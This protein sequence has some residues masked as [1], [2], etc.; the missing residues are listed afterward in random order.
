MF[1]K[2]DFTSKLTGDLGEEKGHKF[3]A[4]GAIIYAKG[5]NNARV[6]VGPNVALAAAKDIK[7]NST[8]KIE[9]LFIYSDS[10]AVSRTESATGEQNAVSAA[11]IYSDISQDSSV[12]FDD[13]A[14]TNSENQT[15]VTGAK[16]GINSSAEIEYNRIN[17]MIQ[18]VKD[19][20]ATL[21]TTTMSDYQR[22][23]LTDLENSWQDV[24]NKF[25]AVGAEGLTVSENIKAFSSALVSLGG[26]VGA[27]ADMAAGEVAVVANAAQVVSA[28]SEFLSYN[29]FLN[30]S[31]SSTV[32]GGSAE[33]SENIGVSGM[34]GI[35]NFSSN[36]DV[37]IGRNVTLKTPTPGTDDVAIDINSSTRSEMITSA[38]HIIPSSGATSFGGTYLT[39]DYDLISNVMV[40]E[41]ADI[42]SGTK[43][44][45]LNSENES[46]IA[47]L[48]LSTAMAASG[49]DGMYSQ[50]KADSKAELKI[51]DEVSIDAR[52]LELL[53]SNNSKVMNVAGSV[54][55]TSAK[56]AGV[57]IAVNDLT[58]TSVAAI[59]D[60]DKEYQD[61]LKVKDSNIT[62]ADSQR[63]RTDAKISLARELSS[64]A[65]SKGRVMAL[66]VAG[67][68][69]TN[70]D[71]SEPGFFSNLG[72]KFGSI[73]NKVTDKIDS[74]GT[75][76]GTGITSQLQDKS[77]TTDP[78]AGHTNP[79]F[80]LSVAGSLGLNNVDNTTTAE[81][82]EATIELNAAND[83]NL[84]LSAI[85]DSDVLAGAGA[86]GVM[87]Q[88]A[89][90]EA[91][92]KAKSVS[93]AGAAGINKLVSNT[94]ALIS[95]SVINKAKNME[96]YA[97][98]GG[99]T[100][101]A[102]LGMQLSK[103]TGNAKEAYTAGSSISINLIEN[104]IKALVKNS[105][106]DGKTVKTN[107]DV[108]AY[109]GGNQYTGG[110]Q[111]S[112]GTVNGAIGA[113]VNVANITNN[114]SSQIAGGTYSN[115]NAISVSALQALTQVNA[116][117]TAG[118]IWGTD[119]STA[120][121]GALVYNAL[122]NQ[123]NS[124]I[125]SD[126]NINADADVSLVACDS[127][128]LSQDF[129]QLL[130]QSDHDFSSFI[131]DNGSDYANVS[132]ENDVDDSTTALD[133]ST[134]KGGLIVTSAA[135]LNSG[136]G[137]F[138]AGLVINNI[139]NDYRA[140]IDSSTV[141]ADSIKTKAINNNLFV[142]VAGG[143]AVASKNVA[144]SGSA[145]WNHIDATI[146]S[147]HQNSDLTANNFLVQALNASK[148]TSVA[149]TIA[150]GK[151][152]IGLAFSFNNLN[153]NINAYSHATNI[154]GKNAGAST[155]Q[156][157]AENA[158]DLLNIGACAEISSELSFGGSLIIN[159]IIDTTKATVNNSYL[160]Q[161]DDQQTRSNVEIKNIKSVDINANNNSK[162]K[163][164]VADIV[165]SKEAGLG[166]ARAHNLIKND[167]ESDPDSDQT[168]I[169]QASAGNLTIDAESVDIIAKNS[170]DINAWATGFAIAGESAVNGAIAI[171]VIDRQ[172]DA[173]AENLQIN[174]A[175]SSLNINS[176]SDGTIKSRALVAAAS[177]D[178][179]VG[180]GVATNRITDKV[181]AYVSDGEL[182]LKNLEVN[183]AASHEIHA[184]GVSGAAGSATLS[185]SVG[186]NV[187]D[188][189]N[190]AYI[191][192]GAKV[193]AQ[194]NVG[195]VALT[196]DLLGNYA[197]VAAIGAEAGIGA[198]VSVN[199]ILGETN[200]Y[201][202]EATINAKGAD[203]GI[204]VKT[205]ISDDDMSEIYDE[206]LQAAKKHNLQTK[207]QETTQKGIVIDS[208]S[209]ASF[210]SFTANA[211]LSGEVALA[212]T[213]NVN[214][215]DG[216][217]SAMLSQ[218]EINNES[219]YN[220]D[221]VVNSADYNNLSSFV[222]SAEIAGAAGVGVSVDTNRINRESV[223][224]IDRV[225]GSKA[226]NIHLNATSKQ[227]MS[228][229]SAGLALGGELGIAGS[230]STFYLTGKTRA[231][232]NN[233]VLACSDMNINA[234]R[235]AKT[236]SNNSTISA[237][238]GGIGGSVATLIDKQKV[239]AIVKSAH[240][241]AIGAVDIKTKNNSV[242]HT[243]ALG[244]G[245]G[246][247]GG[248]GNVAVNYI[249]TDVKAELTGSSIG[250]SNEAADSISIQANNSS[251]LKAEIGTAGAGGL[252]AGLSV[253]VN[254][255]DGKVRT[256][257]DH[258][259]LFANN[260]I[261]VKTHNH[262]TAEVKTFTVAAGV[263]AASVNVAVLSSGKKLE[264]S[265][266]D[267]NK[268]ASDGIDA[269]EKSNAGA[270]DNTH[271]ALTESE[272]KDLN[273]TTTRPVSDIDNLSETSLAIANNSSVHSSNGGVFI[274]ATEKTDSDFIGGAES[275]GGAAAGA[276]VAIMNL[277]RN[278]GVTISDSSV[279]SMGDLNIASTV[280]GASSLKTYQGT[281]AAFAGGT[282]AYSRV[283]TTGSSFIDI[284]NAA[285]TSSGHI[286]L[287]GQ[288][289]SSVDA[290]G[291]GL[292]GS[293]L[294]AA[295]YLKTKIVND[296]S[297]NVK[298]DNN[299]N[300]ISDKNIDVEAS[301]K[302]ALTS[303]AKNGSIGLGF[304]GTGVSSEIIDSGMAQV[305]QSGQGSSYTGKKISFSA[306]NK[307]EIT[308][309]ATGDSK[310][311]A[312]S[313]ALSFASS[314][315]TS[316]TIVEFGSGNYF[317]SKNVA[318]LGK[319]EG[320]NTVFTNG[321]SGGFV[322]SFGYNSS[323]AVNDST[324]NISVGDNEYQTDTDLQLE[325]NNNVNQTA[326]T[327]GLSVGGLIASG[328]NRSETVSKANISVELA[329]NSTDDEHLNSVS[330][331]ADSSNSNFSYAN[332]DGG[333]LISS[334][335]LSAKA[336]NS[337]NNTVVA[338][339]S[340]KWNIA[341]D[342][343]LNA[344]QTVA[345]T[346]KSSSTKA[347]VVGYSGTMAN[348]NITM[349][350]T[351]ELAADS[352]LLTGGDTR[353]KAL[354]V[355]G[356]GKKN[357]VTAA[358]GGYGG[359][360]VNGSN[361]TLEINSV[362]DAK[363]GENSI[364][365]STRGKINI[366]A[367]TQSE[368]YN[369]AK[370]S[371][372]GVVGVPVAISNNDLTIENSA[373][374]ADQAALRTFAADKDISIA[375]FDKTTAIL[376]SVSDMQGGLGGEARA[377][378]N[379]TIDRS[380]SLDIK[381]A[382]T[383]SNDVN[384]YTD[385]N[386]AG[387][388]SDYSLTATADAY[389]KHSAVALAKAE[390]NSTNNL[391]NQINIAANSDI[392]S[393]RHIN[394]GA[395]SGRYY[396]SELANEYTWYSSDTSGGH[397][398][399]ASGDNS[400]S[401]VKNNHVAIDG[402][403]IA[404]SQNKLDINI[405]G[406]V[407]F[408]KQIENSVD[409]PQI[410]INNEQYAKLIKYGDFD[411]GNALFDRF[412]EVSKLAVEYVGS[413]AGIGYEAEKL[414]LLDEMERFGLYDPA[415]GQV[416]GGMIV[417]YIE[418]P[419]MVSSGG[420]LIINTDKVQGT[421]TIKAQGSPKINI[422]N[423]SNLYTKLGG[424]QIKDYG[425]EVILNKV[426]LGEEAQAKLPTLKTVETSDAREAAII[427]KQEWQGTVE[428]Q[429]DDGSKR[430]FKPLTSIEINGNVSNPLGTIFVQTKQ[431]DIVIQ[432]KTAKESVSVSGMEVTL[433][434]DQGS[435]AQGFTKGIVNVNSNP[436]DVYEHYWDNAKETNKGGEKTKT[437]KIISKND[438]D[439]AL[440]HGI[441]IAGGSVYI[442]A[443]DININGL[444]QSGY[445]TYN[446]TLDDAAET[447]IKNFDNNYDGRTI[448]SAMLKDYALNE[449]GAK[450]VFQKTVDSTTVTV[451]KH[452]Y[453]IQ[454]YYNP[455]TQQI[456]LEEV[457]PQG[458]KIFL[459]GRV[460]S[461]GNGRIV[462][463][464]GAAEVDIT[465]NTFRPI[466]TANIGSGNAEGLVRIT[467]SAKGL[468]T[469]FRRDSTTNYDIGS[470]DKTLSA[471]SSI[472]KPKEGL[473]YNWTTGL[474]RTDEKYKKYVEKFLFWGGY[475]Y[476]KDNVETF[477]SDVTPISNNDP[478]I[479]G[480]YI[481]NFH[482][483]PGAEF[484]LVYENDPHYTSIPN[485]NNPWI[486]RHTEYD[487]KLHFHGKNIYEAGSVQGKIV[488]YQ[489]SLNASNDVS[490]RFIG[491]TT[492]GHI[493]ITSIDDITLKGDV[494]GIEGTNVAIESRVGAIDQISG[495]ISADKVSLNAEKGIGNNYG[496][497]H[498]V[499]SDTATINAI[500]TSGNITINSIASINKQGNLGLIAKAL[501][502]KVK[503]TSDGSI[504]GQLPLSGDKASVI[505]RR[506]DLKS[507]EE[508]VDITNLSSNIDALKKLSSAEA[509]DVTW[510][511]DEGIAV[512]KR[513][514]GIGIEMSS[515]DG[516]LKATANK[517][518][519]IAASTD[520][521]IY[522]D[523]INAG[524][525]NI[526]LLGRDGVYN[527]SSLPTTVNLK[528]KDLII[529]G[530][531]KG[532]K[533]SIGEINRPI[534]IDLSGKLT[535]RAE[536]LINISQM[537]TD[538]MIL[539]ALYGASDV[540][541]KALNNI[542]S[543]YSGIPSEDLG[544]INTAGKLTLI[545]AQGDIGES[546]KGL[547]ILADNTESVDA[548]GNDI[549]LSLKTESADDSTL[550]FTSLDT[551]TTGKIE[552]IGKDV[553]V[554]FSA[555][556]NA[557]TIS[558]AT[559][560]ATQSGNST[561]KTASLNATTS[562]GQIFANNNNE[563][564]SAQLLNSESGNIS[565]HTT[566]ILSIKSAI[567]QAESGNL[568]L[569][570]ASTIT[571]SGNISAGGDITINADKGFSSTATI[572]S[573]NDMHLT[574]N[575]GFVDFDKIDAGG[576]IDI[577][578]NGYIK[579]DNLVA[580]NDIIIDD[581]GGDISLNKADAGRDIIMTALDSNINIASTFEADRDLKVE[582]KDLIAD[583]LVAGRDLSLTE[584]SG[585]IDFVSAKAG[586]DVSLTTAKS[587]I[588]ID[589]V[590]AGRDLE[591]L[592]EYG[593]IRI[594]DKV[595]SRSGSVNLI[596]DG[597][598]NVHEILAR[599]DIK[600]LSNDGEIMI[601][602]LNGKR[603]TLVVNHDKKTVNVDEVNVGHE[604]TV[605]ASTVNVDKVKHTSD[606]DFLKMCFSGVNNSNMDDINIRQ[607]DSQ[608]GVRVKGLWTI[609]G[610]LHTNSEYFRLEDVYFI[611]RGYLSNSQMTMT[612]FGQNPMLDGSDVII[613]FM[614]T[615]SGV[616]T[617][618]SFQNEFGSST[619]YTLIYA[620]DRK[621]F[622]S[623]EFTMM[624][625]AA[626]IAKNDILGAGR[627]SQAGDSQMFAASIASNI[628][629]DDHIFTELLQQYGLNYSA[630]QHSSVLLAYDM[631]SGTLYSTAQSD[632]EDIKDQE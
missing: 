221:L 371:G 50:L 199:H 604:M 234:Y 336:I 201:I 503:I 149:G 223:A 6:K 421:G 453:E 90:T 61:Y 176:A 184:I 401:F 7:I 170:A 474:N 384:F 168:S 334:D 259:N 18:D 389:N 118:I 394:L 500:T 274:T 191:A 375:A 432:G 253:G 581:L 528:G 630:S 598:I 473:Y 216:K 613:Y 418:L 69:I 214:T 42:V 512:I 618:I 440:Q 235:W 180:A 32:K 10:K 380:N 152:A 592:S 583:T 508:I 17:R 155:L 458:G 485:S 488:T 412:E 626:A 275:A 11:I 489:H 65:E 113:A 134:K 609:T 492:G 455:Q 161:D 56:G 44:S 391:N 143:V 529:E 475:T 460:S 302:N 420:N 533:S 321:A 551:D 285:L 353:I 374:I 119:S 101:A 68:I 396:L 159:E 95:D 213:V 319:V 454:A 356:V 507:T 217:T 316:K 462:A 392:S 277:N 607:I 183:S 343:L 239:H 261:A 433:T 63:N 3:E 169:T 288:D 238:L 476:G 16:I 405:S 279:S 15:I 399:T 346:L 151:N 463:F 404:G 558:L 435:V 317:N 307:P 407:D 464:D 597:D 173:H 89:T 381:G 163:S 153:N 572:N 14:H 282:A 313:G 281:I 576:D 465:N 125:T 237:G 501:D 137:A 252:G 569:Q 106:V 117:L 246:V 258:S 303:T 110:A 450:Y 67:G 324:V 624:E 605:T 487:D 477:L 130:S 431:G 179:S 538:P 595:E 256:L 610:K 262:K 549:Y 248:A 29:N 208:S 376:N 395:S 233:S 446:L 372:A 142:S 241:S 377:V 210:K 447:K 556:L 228:S 148:L 333:G 390:V 461:T 378:T 167:D 276:S 45:K 499:L 393:V 331:V 439:L 357:K 486:K 511:E 632:E 73:T 427:A 269:S 298:F 481:G 589:S 373:I 116:A 131:S 540:M 66:G 478:K 139:N 573:G 524:S 86:V 621:R 245:G 111:L 510:K 527:V 266:E 109:E 186:V 172:I 244:I 85:N 24:E 121:M 242:N 344:L 138:G 72:D 305:K 368:I 82:S 555:N 46:K 602:K 580:G 617:N 620:K 25:S 36:S 23:L 263:G 326:H 482:K 267:G 411:Y 189:N 293:G 625:R 509:S 615:S 181:S 93:V 145:N 577:N 60:I 628:E 240:I 100:I 554:S 236:F 347:A 564:D 504:F 84:V 222:G 543:V 406:T 83:S 166:G 417:Q 300:L 400:K 123:L 54:M 469:E 22:A 505:A 593:E 312:V 198:A 622:S 283:N 553:G 522:L 249:Q 28:A 603:V 254:T 192:D 456:I 541:L 518:I 318:F 48:G 129:D 124:S 280:D 105:V 354:N 88:T 211:S 514:T 350:T 126:A 359:I 133:L 599:Q 340:G 8:A 419:N 260:D 87:W 414:R 362:V 449:G 295:G 196:N 219:G 534:N 403:L 521:P 247:I 612:V 565:L 12:I 141:T 38:G 135:S 410:I 545:S 627:V 174:N 567:N 559:L 526:R 452:H 287:S 369:I 388:T 448:T 587:N 232:I 200:S 568:A 177:K 272:T 415:T 345:T 13:A 284:A 337:I 99:G 468:V 43:D 365:H 158:T 122:S 97:V 459:T 544:Y 409:K 531:A 561:I 444:I 132:V 578:S 154:T 327:S 251:K 128:S 1:K 606:N 584:H 537:S 557:D 162:I 325:S 471:A 428:V 202:D 430:D 243:Q 493:N 320:T 94:K 436:E 352:Q 442:N 366:E 506:I 144:G 614:P 33:D 55:I 341:E 547:R 250:T 495:R 498:R 136:K 513:T 257:V 515:A 548:S 562:K 194:D 422:I 2:N 361:S 363:I 255:L 517:N 51:D 297:V 301:R 79:S 566:G 516:K 323:K 195:V 47:F 264:D 338:K 310:S 330:V 379:S 585:V 434:A 397:T 224:R 292:T 290:Y 34:I 291:Y 484:V 120:I 586:R 156:L 552:I 185:G 398:T 542:N 530:G 52:N 483:R 502:G 525:S 467:D 349:N 311:L 197:G 416:I 364:V 296:S 425:G 225:T 429:T 348:N 494:L 31:V 386:T 579:G 212:G 209:V 74:L 299:S 171:S 127:T 315:I 178:L 157:T 335:G 342:L 289:Q 193:W 4:A 59:K 9:D 470:T 187:I 591:M 563:I 383:S 58:K 451:D 539:S 206:S 479:A 64:V 27:F 35:N 104:S 424:L 278:V 231:K 102:G 367:S 491:S 619:N 273:G 438:V 150:A 309:K 76:F 560:S 294:I 203:G 20:I 332:G 570:T 230:V 265:S 623:N 271:E 204:T 387:Q 457:D 19:A 550:D 207:R 423:E 590:N 588:L 115:I 114:I 571:A 370:T 41:G 306:E 140:E 5:D 103:N 496:I 546:G 480:T 165:A 536:G 445:A 490:V 182:K 472:Y 608:R 146:Y 49:I 30:Y 339:L 70:S 98:N 600:G 466:T 413:E 227:P 53:A 351:A 220:S 92:K 322:G 112:I 226:R 71:D 441:I 519:Y 314:N 175:N 160:D 96:V 78:A 308:A 443:S 360:L 358:G 108:A 355:I 107:I 205:T 629:V 164:V 80:S 616:F 81:I 26:V 426:S 601:A 62:G 385:S 190:Q 574:T 147:G 270:I 575:K 611:D 631:N 215:I 75:T 229:T 582:A 329:G 37:L 328:N 188:T 21:K 437:T 520:D 91:S 382:L 57:G 304:A 402:N 497:D 39:Q 77:A 40:A 596:A 532:Q 218:S 268:E 408:S 286:N 535:A 523:N 594:E